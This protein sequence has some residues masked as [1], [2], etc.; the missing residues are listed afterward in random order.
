MCS[1]LRDIAREQQRSAHETMPDQGLHHDQLSLVARSI[2]IAGTCASKEDQV[3]KP[4]RWYVVCYGGCDFREF[5]SQL[6]KPLFGR[7]S[8]LLVRKGAYARN[9]RGGRKSS[10][11]GGP[12]IDDAHGFLLHCVGFT[13]PII[14][15]GSSLPPIAA[16]RPRRTP[17][18]AAGE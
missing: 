12:A 4:R 7:G 17:A 11:E 10:D 16:P 5:N 6:T 18:A 14:A 13:S 9:D 1:T 3:A 15:W 2:R 8:A